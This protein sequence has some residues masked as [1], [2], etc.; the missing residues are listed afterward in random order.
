MICD[1]ICNYIIW[2]PSGRE[3]RPQ[4]PLSLSVLADAAFRRSLS[5]SFEGLFLSVVVRLV[6]DS[7][8]TSKQV[9][10]P[11]LSN[12]RKAVELKKSRGE[13]AFL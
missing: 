11:A 13:N 7:F 9:N 1:I 4:F 5:P 3:N 10:Q 12:F 6:L 2:L 8:E